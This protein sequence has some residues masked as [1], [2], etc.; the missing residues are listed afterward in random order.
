M[1]K[2][3]LLN[4]NDGFLRT[5][6]AAVDLSSSCADFVTSPDLKAGTPRGHHR[7]TF[8]EGQAGTSRAYLYTPK[9]KARKFGTSSN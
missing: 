4:Q 8:R 9:T 1:D 5:R 6:K 2:V 7:H 3:C